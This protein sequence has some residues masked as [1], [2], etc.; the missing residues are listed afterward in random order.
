M[1]NPQEV[2]HIKARATARQVRHLEHMEAR[3]TG[4]SADAAYKRVVGHERIHV[5]PT[6]RYAGLTRHGASRLIDAYHAAE[7]KDRRG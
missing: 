4:D 7:K 6:H 2:K 3:L 5:H 1:S